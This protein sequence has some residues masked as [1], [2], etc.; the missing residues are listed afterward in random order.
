MHFKGLDC[1]V[2]PCKPE[3]K[4]EWLLNDPDLNGK[5][6][7]LKKDDFKLVSILFIFIDA[8]FCFKLSHFWQI[9]SGAISEFIEKTHPEP[10]LKIDNMDKA[11]EVQSAFFP[12]MAKLVKSTKPQADLEKAFL[13][14]AKKLNDHL[15]SQNTKY[16]SGETISLIDFSLSPKLYHMDVCL[17]EFHPKVHEKVMKM[18]ALKSYMDVMFAQEAFQATLYPKETMK[19]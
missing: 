14:Q 3:T 11:T 8:T 5:M 19:S 4:P 18:K 6:P 9:E 2:I 10:P 16:F 1:K 12:A 15:D 7:C 17:A 13:E